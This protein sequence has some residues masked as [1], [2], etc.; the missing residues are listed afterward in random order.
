MDTS[1]YRVTSPHFTADLAVR[2]G[3]VVEA[4]ERVKSWEGRPFSEVMA[5]LRLQSFEVVPLG[6]AYEADR[7][8]TG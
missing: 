1:V 8:E 7:S 6:V 4:G 3:V 5:I 2:D